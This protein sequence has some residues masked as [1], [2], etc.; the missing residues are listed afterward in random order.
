LLQ[1]IRDLFDR[2]ERLTNAALSGEPDM[3][4]IVELYDEAFVGSS[5]AGVMA[6]RKN[7]AFEQALAAGFARNRAIGARTMNIRAVRIEP[8]DERHALAHVDWRAAYDKDGTGKTIDFS[9]CYLA[10]LGNGEARVFG[11]I[12]GDED[13]ALREHGII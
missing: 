3:A 1:A 10:R 4:A 7:D 11:W 8:I 6:G 13:A 2:Y 9:N 12:T 5:P